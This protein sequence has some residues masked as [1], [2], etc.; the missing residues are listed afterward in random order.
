MRI[1]HPPPNLQLYPYQNKDGIQM[2]VPREGQGCQLGLYFIPIAMRFCFPC[3]GLV[4]FLCIPISRGVRE[5]FRCHIA[6]S[7]LIIIELIIVFQTISS[8]GA[9]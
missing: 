2:G 1:F 5:L 4:W 8:F 6:V 9:F 3:V 7:F